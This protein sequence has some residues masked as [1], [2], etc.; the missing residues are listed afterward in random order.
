MAHPSVVQTVETHI[1]TGFTRCR[2]FVE[3]SYVG[4]PESGG[5]WAV[6]DFP[7]CRSTW[8]TA[9]ECEEEGGFR[10]LLAVEAGAGAHEGRDWLEE[11]ATLFRGRLVDGV[12]FYAPQSPLSDDRSDTGASF[13][14]SITVPYRT[15]IVSE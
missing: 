15:I 7:Y 10:V 13:R 6:I 8:I 4:A 12:Q 5:P 2:V 1:E 9:D 14:L 3:N 11:I